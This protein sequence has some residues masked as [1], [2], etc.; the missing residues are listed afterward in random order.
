[1]ASVVS[2]VSK[3]AQEK[4]S[5]PPNPIPSP[6]KWTLTDH[7]KCDHTP[8]C[9]PLLCWGLTVMHEILIGS[10]SSKLPLHENKSCIESV[11]TVF[12]MTCDQYK[13]PSTVWFQIMI[14]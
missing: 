1:M 7:Y 11:S 4:T 9:N 14:M 2:I 3:Q 10:L 13:W 12:E 5:D 6:K 8:R